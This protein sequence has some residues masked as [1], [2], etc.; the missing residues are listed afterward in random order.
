MQRRRSWLRAISLM[1]LLAFGPISC[2]SETVA[3]IIVL[4]DGEV[5]TDAIGFQGGGAPDGT[6]SGS[7]ATGGEEDTAESD[8]VETKREI[9]VL[10]N[11]DVPQVLGPSGLL[12]VNVK[13]I[14]YSLGSPASGVPV[15]F[16]IIE[17][18]GLF[19]PGAGG[20][21]SMMTG[22]DTKG[23][24]GNVFRANK[25]PA[26][27]YKIKIS[28]EGAEPVFFSIAVTDTPK[29][30][31]RVSMD[32]DNQVALSQVVVRL[33]PSPFTCSSFKPVYPAAGYVGSKAAFLS[34]KVDFKD[35]AADKKYA[36]YLIAKDNNN[37][38]A[39]AGCADGILVIDKQTTEVTVTVKT[40]TL[41]ASGPYDMVNH[42]DFTG[43]VPG[44]LGQILDT[45]VQIFYDPGAFI[46][47]QIK[48]LIKQWLPSILVDA[49]FG[50]FED[51]LA[52]VVT[53]WL[54]TS[55]PAW[56]QDFFQIG[57]DVLQIV[58]KLEMLGT[59]TIFKV[60]NDFFIKGEI[61]FTGVNLYWKLGCDKNDPNYK[62]CG[63]LTLDMK[64]AVSDP[65]FPLDL[66]AGTMTG[67]ISGQT[68]LTIDS[69]TI[70]L[71]YGKLIYYVLTFVVLKK[72]TGETS[73]QGAMSKLVNCAGIAKGIGGSI[74]GKL[75]LSETNVKSACNSA[76]S[77]LVLPIEQLLL[78]LT[79]DSKL[80]LSGYCDMVD[81]LPPVDATKD[82][83]GD[84]KVDR[85]VDGVWQGSIVADTPG[86]PFK[87][88]FTAERQAGF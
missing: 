34:D 87:G 16:E 76:V 3:G 79:L 4:P 14:D 38:L 69:S 61:N 48:N 77:L 78:G 52:K 31:I 46:I 68:K 82:W 36:V 56:L 44:Q 41:L 66:L 60:S 59:L 55:S 24:T 74:L 40:L 6:G 9:I 83:A 50:L 70:K 43:A 29:G 47:S 64:Q 58:K 37:H 67:T 80:A 86:K 27:D 35:L 1:V 22:T 73:F 57:Q 65:N 19:G 25:S 28:C 53:N 18:T 88:D 5:Q 39:A 17:N 26:V 10:L 71:N 75:G 8:D 12:A 32:Y 7:D 49:A 84:L 72:I 30:T 45:A 21:D 20:F 11:T 81:D 42:F 54:L 63:K 85:L 13:V 62:D 2:G 15:F 23:L 33:M 51:A